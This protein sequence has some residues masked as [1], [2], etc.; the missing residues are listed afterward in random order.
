MTKLTPFRFSSPSSH[1]PKWSDLF[2]L[3]HRDTLMLRG[4]NRQEEHEKRE[5]SESLFERYSFPSALPVESV[6]AELAGV[7]KKVLDK[8]AKSS[9]KPKA[10]DEER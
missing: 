10:K 7:A 1:R 4:E 3:W 8:L 2:H 6:E 5:R 9:V